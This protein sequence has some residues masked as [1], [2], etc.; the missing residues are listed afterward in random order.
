MRRC[1]RTVSAP[2]MAG[3]AVLLAFSFAGRSQVSEQR[4]FVIEV[5]SVPPLSRQLTAEIQDQSRRKVAE[6]LLGGDD[7][8]EF[9]G[10]P[11]G[12]YWL[13]VA[14]GNGNTLSQTP[15]SVTPGTGNMI[16]ELAAPKQQR[17]PSGGVSVSEL[18]KPPAREAVRAA[19]A[20][21][22][23]ARRMPHSAVDL[24]RALLHYN[25]LA[26]FRL[27]KLQ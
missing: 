22:K 15:V 16:L 11:S 6:A 14:D 17:P 21:Q 1:S 25:A 10:V 26:P 27:S 3:M 7:Q 2:G 9:R 12:Q 20:A 8:F 18:Q 5:R 23:H 13:V 19:V 4:P 24:Q